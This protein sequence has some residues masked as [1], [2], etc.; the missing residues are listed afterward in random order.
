MPMQEDRF[1]SAWQKI[2]LRVSTLTDAFNFNLLYPARV[3]EWES[4][5]IFPSGLVG[6]VFVSDDVGQAATKLKSKKGIPVLP[7]V[8]GQ[9]YVPKVGSQILVGWQGG[10]ERFPYATGWLGLG[11][12][13]SVGHDFD[14]TY[15][16]TGDLVDVVG[17]IRFQHIRLG[18]SSAR[19]SV[20]VDPAFAAVISDLSITGSDAFFKVDFT[21][22]PNM[23]ITQLNPGDSVVLLTFKK[24][25]LA[26]PLVS[27][28]VGSQVTLASV[29]TVGA[30]V[31]PIEAITMGGA[32]TGT[33]LTADPS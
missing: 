29:T 15:T 19:P 9:R 12:A 18:G 11:G 10:D 26:A 14:T 2:Q 16:F 30:A 3:V 22:T 27:P 8:V 23:V 24:P 32:V 1:F 20:V 6:V 31:T 5:D 33:I 25:Y 28:A 7:P 4:S 13:V 21:F 17:D